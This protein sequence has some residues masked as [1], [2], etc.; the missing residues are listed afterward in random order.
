MQTWEKITYPILTA[1]I[2]GLITTGSLWF[3]DSK[4]ESA[5]L[6]EK[7]KMIKK[8]IVENT[9]LALKVKQD[10]NTLEIKFDSILNNNSKEHLKLKE[11]MDQ[12]G[13]YI[14]QLTYVL[15]KRDKTLKEDLKE[16]KESFK[17]EE[18]IYGAK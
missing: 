17:D 3:L 7:N 16:I 8:S 2:I 15:N 13:T 1:L 10:C 6:I 18:Y 11:G 12:L 5:V 4:V 14:N 9:E